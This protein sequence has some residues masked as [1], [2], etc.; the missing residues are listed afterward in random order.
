MAGS[1]GKV[2]S[3]IEMSKKLRHLVEYFAARIFLAVV[4]ILSIETCQRLSGWFA[5]LAADVF[6]FRSQVIS[7]NISA[8]YPELTKG[9]IQALTRKM[10]AH[11]GLMVCEI[12]HA[13]RKIH[14][15][16]WRKYVTIRDRRLISKYLI[17]PRPLVIVTGHFGNFEVAGYLNGLLGWHSYA[18]A[19][20][21]DNPYLDRLMKRFRETTGQFIL[22]KDGSTEEIQQV[23]DAGCMLSLLGDQ[24]AGTKGV[25]IDFLGRPA[26]C[27]KALALFTLINRAPMLVSYCRRTSK[28][29]NFEIGTMGIADPMT[30]PDELEN[31]K[32][33]T[34]WYNDRLAKIINAVPDQF[35]WV[36]R[37]WKPK[38]V[39]KTSKRARTA[40]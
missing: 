10:W 31:V 33:L 27:H 17:D 5:W 21:L 24:H 36:H 20:P 26:A 4:Q 2:R 37:R 1:C 19:R 29:L 18:V 3:R 12:A 34:Q 16:N 23:L 7:Q 8:T 30:L 13:R 15:T 14:T 40:A 38:P 28:P 6:R 32:P 11:L 22:P 39:R 25:W 35:W 9:E